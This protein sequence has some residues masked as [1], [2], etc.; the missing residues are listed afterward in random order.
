MA[1]PP[2]D[3]GRPWIALLVALV[4]L[5]GT[6]WF[7]AGADEAA[8]DRPTLAER[9]GEVAAAHP[10]DTALLVVP[11]ELPGGWG[12]PGVETS[13]DGDRLDRFELRVVR[14]YDDPDKDD[15]FVAVR[16]TVCTAVDPAPC[17]DGRTEL[18]ATTEAGLTTV[19]AIDDGRFLD[20]VGPAWDDVELTAD[21]RT[22]DW[23]TRER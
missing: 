3:T 19:I 8:L 5:A 1:R 20:Q 15:A 22:L 17:R 12:E 23:P 11:D 9:L 16:L 18:R 21:W 13:T 2:I 7:F 6:V 14:R 4:A 10:D